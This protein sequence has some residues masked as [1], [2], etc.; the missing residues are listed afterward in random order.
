MAF[1]ESPESYRVAFLAELSWSNESK[2]YL[3]C[4]I[5]LKFCTRLCACKLLSYK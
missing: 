2:K 5:K 3:L 4:C 1:Q